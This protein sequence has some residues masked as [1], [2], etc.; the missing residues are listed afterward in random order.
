MYVTESIQLFC[1]WQLWHSWWSILVIASTSSGLAV[2]VVPAIIMY[3]AAPIIIPVVTSIS[4]YCINDVGV[5]EGFVSTVSP[6]FATIASITQ[7]VSVLLVILF[8]I[9]AWAWF[10][11]IVFSISPAIGDFH[12][13]DDG[14]RLLTIEFFNV[15]FMLDTITK[16]LDCPVDGDIFGSVQKLSEAPDVCPLRLLRLLVT[17]A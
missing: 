14:L 13:F 7:I 15:R 12:E 11:H 6:L 8:V 4:V 10:P 1:K 17:L 3:V 16:I 5:A 9:T 2:V